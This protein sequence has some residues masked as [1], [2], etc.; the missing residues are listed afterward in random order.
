MF[1]SFGVSGRYPTQEG[2]TAVGGAG[3]M[4]YD[5]SDFVSFMFSRDFI[6]EKLT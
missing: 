1:E 2:Q 6:P 3:V 4:L 5:V